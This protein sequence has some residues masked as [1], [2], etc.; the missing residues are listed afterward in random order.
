MQDMAIV[1]IEDKEEL[2]C[3][4]SNDAIFNELQ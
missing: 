4:L 2:V 3:D 1:T